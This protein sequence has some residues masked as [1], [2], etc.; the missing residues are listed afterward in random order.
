MFGNQYFYLNDHNDHNVNF[1]VKKSSDTVGTQY[2]FSL[3]VLLYVDKV[4]S[5]RFKLLLIEV[6]LLNILVTE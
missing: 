1:H 6:I 5:L 3:T 4:L 2:T